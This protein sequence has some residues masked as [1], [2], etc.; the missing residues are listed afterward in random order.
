MDRTQAFLT[1]VAA[2]GADDQAARLLGRAGH[3]CAAAST[4]STATTRCS[5]AWFGGQRS[6]VRAS[7]ASRCAASHQADLERRRRRRRRGTATTRCVQAAAQRTEV[8]RHRDVAELSPAER[9]ELARLFG[10][11]A[12]A[13]AA[14]V[15]PRRRPSRR[16]EIDARR[17][18]REQLRHGGE[19]ARL[20]SRAPHARG[21]RRVVVLDRRLRLDGPVRRQ[22]AALGAR[23]HQRS[24]A[25]APRCSRSAPG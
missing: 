6:R 11:P 22:P 20:Q 21:R 4:T 13:A 3:A 24:T 12:P 19:P 25:P 2:V 7:H 5:L 23:R 18:L 15:S 1:A 8:L 14:P 9:A 16:G 10:T 17:T